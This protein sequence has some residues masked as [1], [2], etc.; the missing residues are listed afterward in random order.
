[1]TSSDVVTGRSCHYTQ[2]FTT[3]KAYINV[4]FFVV[5]GIGT[6]HKKLTLWPLVALPFQILRTINRTAAPLMRKRK[7]C[8]TR[9]TISTKLFTGT[10]GQYNSNAEER[11]RSQNSVTQEASHLRVTQ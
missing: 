8:T 11:E 1:M 4:F 5:E 9:T 2:S 10:S 3:H 7:H 6:D